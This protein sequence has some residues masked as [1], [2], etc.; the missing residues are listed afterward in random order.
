MMEWDSLLKG[1]RRKRNSITSHKVDCETATKDSRNPMERDF[2][3]I[4]FL[5]PTRRLSDKTQVFPLDKN[6]SVRTRLTH[7]YE[8]ANLARGIGTRLVYEHAELFENYHT[9]DRIERSIP[10]LLATIGLAH[11]LGNP[12]FGHQGESAIG[13]W[14]EINKVKVFSDNVDCSDYKD[15]IAFDGNSQ[16]IRLLT[17]LQIL[18]DEFGI[19]LTY[20]SL[21]ALLKYPQS[22]EFVF[23]Q[24][25]KIRDWKE[26]KTKLSCEENP[27]QLVW[28]KHGFFKSEENI[29]KDIWTETG[30]E[31]GVRHPLTYIMEACDDIAYSVLDAE[32]IVKK[33][34]ASFSDLV[35]YLKLHAFDCNLVKNVVEKAIQKNEEYSK[36]ELSPAELNELSMQMFRVYAMGELVNGIVR[37]FVE[38]HDS[39]LNG[40]E[41]PKD[42]MSLS[43]GKVLCDTLKDFDKRWG[44]RNKT[45]L[46]LE[47]EGHNYIQELMDMLWI[48]IHGRIDK[49]NDSMTPFGKYAYEKISENYRRVFENDKNE[50]SMMYREAQLL[51]DAISGMTDS[52]LITLHTEL[53]KLYKRN[54][55]KLKDF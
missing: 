4:L 22:S 16:T 33:G 47:L 36:Q 19:D 54:D 45:V 41:Q 37:T 9:S 43:D 27:H 7:S 29:I 6:D 1:T 15:F 23:E 55:Y 28:K 25:E 49:S 11:D 35:N 38:K 10:S 53:K 8:V 5:A 12:P 31:L 40:K 24:K 21:A 20:A 52:Y 13:N 42:L 14:F 39:L 30:L 18:N 50:M 44:Y 17:R 2:D 48:G 46:K 32:D 51:T 34:L 26:S 3:R